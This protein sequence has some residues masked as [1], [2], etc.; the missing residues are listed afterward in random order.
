MTNLTNF[1]YVRNKQLPLLKWSWCLCS[2][3]INISMRL[4]KKIIGIFTAFPMIFNRGGQSSKTNILYLYG[5]TNKLRITNLN[6]KMI[7]IW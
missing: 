2:V 3:L 1:L 6:K 4:Q 7:L 5:T